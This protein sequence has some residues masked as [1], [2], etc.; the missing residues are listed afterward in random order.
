MPQQQWKTKQVMQ[1]ASQKINAAV[2]LPQT[3]VVT[4]PNTDN[5]IGTSHNVVQGILPLLQLGTQDASK[6][7]QPV[8][9]LAIPVESGRVT[10]PASCSTTSVSTTEPPTETLDKESTSKRKRKPTMEAQALKANER[11]KLSKK[12]AAKKQQNSSV[13]Q[14]VAVLPQTTAWILTPTGLMPVTRIQLQGPGIPGHQNQ[15]TPTNVQMV[16]QPP[17]VVNQ[18]SCVALT[19]AM[20]PSN[21]TPDLPENTNISLTAG[22]NLGQNHRPSSVSDNHIVSSHPSS[23]FPSVISAAVTNM[24]S[25]PQVFPNTNV[26]TSITGSAAQVPPSKTAF[27]QN[28]SVT[29]MSS[30]SPLVSVSSSPIGTS[31]NLTASCIL[32]TTKNVTNV[33]SVSAVTSTPSIP[34]VHPLNISGPGTNP[35]PQTQRMLHPVSQVVFQQPIMVSQN[36]S[37]AL[38][39]TAGPCLPNVP[40][41]AAANASRLPTESTAPTIN[42]SLPRSSTKGSLSLINAAGPCL[43][44]T[45]PP[46]ATGNVT[47]VP[48][49]SAAPNINKSL[50]TSSTEGPFISPAYSIIPTSAPSFTSNVTSHATL[51]S[52]FVNSPVTVNVNGLPTDNLFVNLPIGPMT[53]SCQILPQNVVRQVAPQDKKQTVGKAATT[54]NPK[55]KQMTFDP[56]LMFFEQPADVKKWVKGIGGITLPG[57]EDKMPYLPPFV[58]SISTLTTLLKRRDSLLMS[59]VQLLTEE[60][61]DNSEEEA[62][63]AAVRKMVSERFKNNQAYLL[64]KAR[65]LSCFTLP[66]LMATINPC[67][68]SADALDQEDGMDKVKPEQFGDDQFKP[69]SFVWS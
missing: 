38:I 19:N 29:P 41:A 46:P 45:A 53:T 64:L 26:P 30:M 51:Q 52:S 11:T 5:K 66:A 17:V 9:H 50:L 2:I 15:E 28:T 42:K 39:N 44:K 65:F 10:Q 25:V 40:P 16:F 32:D 8:L 68:Q 14:A 48:P 13:T 63:I 61:R 20:R 3:F 24:P 23:D 1:S 31:Q 36:G 33:S 57:L 56:S 12:Q 4:E 59:A 67:I 7:P 18:S 47:R 54:S 43:I 22:P 62:K 60:H 35:G 37:L 34:S 69:S 55:P 6:I 58:S 27:S 49:N 21:P